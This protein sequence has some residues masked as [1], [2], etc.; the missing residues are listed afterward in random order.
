MEGLF[1]NKYR[2]ESIRLKCH[3]YRDPGAYFVTICCSNKKESPFGKVVNCRMR[4]SEV[5]SI[6]MKNWQ[7]IPKHFGNVRLSEFIVMP[8]HV[9]GVIILTVSVDNY[10]IDK[11]NAG[12]SPK[13]GS[14]SVVVRSFKSACSK[15][16][17]DL[18]IKNFKWQTR[19]YDSIIRDRKHLHNVE[20]YIRMNPAKWGKGKGPNNRGK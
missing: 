11:E 7:E 9:H 13:A 19:F 10:I 18:G 3:D 20:N 8:D 12:I 15:K 14:L 5:G 17:H 16:I 2:V 1:K 6:V 4:Y